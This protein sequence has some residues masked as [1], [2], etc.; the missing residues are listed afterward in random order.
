MIIVELKV[1]VLREIEISVE[2]ITRLLIKVLHTFSKIRF[3]AFRK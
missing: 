3:N 1:N 2:M